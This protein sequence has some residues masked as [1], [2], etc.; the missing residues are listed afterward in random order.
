L[1]FDLTSLGRDFE[2]KGKVT[3]KPIYAGRKSGVENEG[4]WKMKGSKRST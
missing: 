2:G 1:L 3:R 4:G